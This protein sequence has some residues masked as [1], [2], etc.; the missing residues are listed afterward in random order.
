MN[1]KFGVVIVTFNRKLLL[2]ECIE[3]VL[4][5]S[6]RFDE[7]IIVDNCSTDGTGDMVR[8]MM[9]EYPNLHY[10]RLQRRIFG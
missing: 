6:R 7:I 4:N 10:Y 9:Q 3:C 8:E 1:Y 5:Q 2:N